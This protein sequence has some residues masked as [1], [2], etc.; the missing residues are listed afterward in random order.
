MGHRLSK[1]T[2]RTGDAGETGIAGQQRYAKTHPRIVAIGE[3][4][5]LNACIGLLRERAL[6]A[7]IDTILAEVQQSL[8]N[9]GGE[10]AMPEATLLTAEAVTE[11]ETITERFNAALPPLEEFI[12]PG[13]PGGAATAHLARTVCRRAERSLWA[14]HAQEALSPFLPQY[15]N[16]LSDLLF[17]FCRVLARAADGEE[18][19]W[20]HERR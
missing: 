5:E 2:T 19:P 16:R 13:G 7:D 8:F 3:V 6:P 17:V 10:L 15:L 9:L 12:L 18:T 1:L 20:R 11:L 4:D 14:A